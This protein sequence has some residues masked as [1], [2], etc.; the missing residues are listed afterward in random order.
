MSLG[1]DPRI[2]IQ[3]MGEK[4]KRG[5]GEERKEEKKK[6]ERERKGG[7]GRKKRKENGRWN[8][9]LLQTKYKKS[10]L[11]RLNDRHKRTKYN[12]F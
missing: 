8:G 7:K 6:G 12:V 3:R 9:F 5:E 11:P 2:Y 4:R 10:F 1:F